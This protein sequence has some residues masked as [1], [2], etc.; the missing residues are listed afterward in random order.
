VRAAAIRKPL[1]GHSEG[2]GAYLTRITGAIPARGGAATL[3]LWRSLTIR[4]W[5]HGQMEPC[6]RAR[7]CSAHIA[8]PW[9]DGSGSLP[10]YRG[11]QHIKKLAPNDLGSQRSKPTN[12]AR[13][14]EAHLRM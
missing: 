5:S 9:G 14:V 2:P 4:L 8:A 1:G 10:A 12:S 7:G 13:L 6:N 11:R 3:N